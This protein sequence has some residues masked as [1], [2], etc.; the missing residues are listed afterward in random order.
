MLSPIDP[1]RAYLF[2]GIAALS[3]LLAMLG[4]FMMLAV[5]LGHASTN[6]T[7]NHPLLL[8]GS[9]LGLALIPFYFLGYWAL[10]SAYPMSPRA[11]F[12]A[13]AAMMAG[14]GALTHGLT[15][16]DI[17]QA[18]STGAQTRPPATAFAENSLLALTALLS[19]LGCLAASIIVVVTDARMP[20]KFMRPAPFVNP[21]LGTIVLSAIAVPLGAAGEYL[22]PA[23]PNLAHFVFFLVS[24]HALR[25]VAWDQ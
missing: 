8:F 11:L 4:D 25:S 15:G 13:C 2:L 14:C 22:G 5:A 23:A 3:A 21:V 16:L 9:I 12:L 6:F 18:L 24:R 19:A 17:H 20:V 7:A 1:N 10:A